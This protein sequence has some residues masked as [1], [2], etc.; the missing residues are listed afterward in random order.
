MDLR[1]PYYLQERNAHIW[2]AQ[3]TV[4]YAKDNAL[5]K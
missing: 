5:T 1:L 3:Y 4:I 2:Q